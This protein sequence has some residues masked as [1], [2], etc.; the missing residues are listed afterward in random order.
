MGVEGKGFTGDQL[1]TEVGADVC[2]RTMQKI[3]REAL[4]DGKHLACMKADSLRVPRRRVEWATFME[5]RYP[6]LEDWYRK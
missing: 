2:G 6:K 1:A 5:A 3:M 4:Y